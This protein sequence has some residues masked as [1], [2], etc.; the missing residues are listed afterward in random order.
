LLCGFERVL[1]FGAKVWDVMNELWRVA[2]ASP[3]APQ[4]REDQS[5]LPPGPLPVGY[6]QRRWIGE[7]N[8]LGGAE[9]EW[10]MENR[11]WVGLSRNW[12]RNIL[13]VNELYENRFYKFA[14]FAT[15]ASSLHKSQNRRYL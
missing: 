4:P 10:L 7:L 9:R 11:L 1:Q 12:R 5:Q 14:R 3:G 13:N 6:N 8:E 2:P 15:N